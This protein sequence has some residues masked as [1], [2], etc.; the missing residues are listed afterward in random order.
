MDGTF[1]LASERPTSSGPATLVTAV[2]VALDADRPV[3]AVDTR[4]IAA[5]RA[6]SCLVEPVVDD[7]V[8]IAETGD[9]VFVLAVLERPSGEPAVLSVPGTDSATLTQDKLAL[10]CEALTVDAGTATLRS[11]A[12]QVA[13]RTLKAVAERLDVVARTLRRTAEQEFSHAKTAVRTVEGAETVTAGELALEAKTAL[14]Q[15]AGI[16]LVDATEDVRINGERITM[17]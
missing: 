7:T 17:G 13:G 8:L 11:R 3:L 9:E 1:L 4:R 6:A 12:A 10:R 5:R 15:R 2:V 14:T 16:V